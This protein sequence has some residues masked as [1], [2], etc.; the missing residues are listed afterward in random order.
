[1]AAPGTPPHPAGLSAAIVGENKRLPTPLE[2]VAAS[3]GEAPVV[4]IRPNWRASS[5]V[6]DMVSRL[7]WGPSAETTWVS[8]VPSE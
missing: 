5:R 1:M 4:R 3:L 2:A 8:T 6:A 7:P